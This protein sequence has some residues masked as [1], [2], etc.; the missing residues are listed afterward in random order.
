[1]KKTI[2]LIIAAVAVFSATAQTSSWAN[3]ELVIKPENM[4]KF[5]AAFDEFYQSEGSKNMPMALLTEN[6]LGNQ[7]ECTHHMSFITDDP[8]MMSDFLNPLIFWSNPDAQKLGQTL[9]A[10]GITPRRAFTGSPVVE[11]KAYPD[12]QNGVQVIWALKVPNNAQFDLINGFTTFVKAMQPYFDASKMEL[13]LQQHLAGDDRGANFWIL[14]SH[15]DY[16]DY[17]KTMNE[18]STNPNFANLFKSFGETENTSTIL[19][20]VMKYWGTPTE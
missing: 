12:A 4:E 11:S 6:S 5:M 1:M 2:L 15:K 13:S 10:I 19:R 20:S 17:M 3:Y 14:A 8:K 16:A 18:M 7:T 9:G